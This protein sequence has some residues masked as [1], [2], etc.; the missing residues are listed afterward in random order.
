MHTEVSAHKP[1]GSDIS[2]Q[3]NAVFAV[4]Y[5]TVASLNENTAITRQFHARLLG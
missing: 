2:T 1:N 4:L 5:N 3:T